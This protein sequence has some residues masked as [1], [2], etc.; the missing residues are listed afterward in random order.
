VGIGPPVRIGADRLASAR[1]ATCQALAITAK[2]AEQL[3]VVIGKTK[4]KNS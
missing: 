1:E 3:R 4:G 2:F